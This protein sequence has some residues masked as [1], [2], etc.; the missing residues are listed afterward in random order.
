MT[1]GSIS[2]I[3]V[4]PGGPTRHITVSVI[5]HL[6]GQAAARP[7]AKSPVTKATA[8]REMTYRMTVVQQNGSWYVAAIGASTQ[9]PA[10]S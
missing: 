3:Q 2:G 1:Y 4:P 10:P 6:A 8:G 7:P 5:W 9:P